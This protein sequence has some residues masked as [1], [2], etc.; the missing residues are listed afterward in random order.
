MAQEPPVVQGIFTVEAS[1]THSDT[2]HSVGL[3]WMSDQS[4]AETS[5]W[6][7]RTLTR[8][9]HAPGGIRTRN[10]SR[11]ATTNPCLWPRCHWDQNGTAI[12]HV[13]FL[14]NYSRPLA[15]VRIHT[16]SHTHHTHTHTYIPLFFTPCSPVIKHLSASL[17][18]KWIPFDATN[19]NVY[20]WYI[21]IYI[22]RYTTHL[23]NGLFN[24]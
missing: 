18:M 19:V 22:Y 16:H 8:D 14:K 9:I 15:T 20:V 23:E 2:L 10:P 1:R 3:L 11:R 5:T 7:S 17:C 12:R 21:Y 24:A 13:I 6:Q 4:D